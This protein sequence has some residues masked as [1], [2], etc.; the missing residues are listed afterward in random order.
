MLCSQ[1]TGE[2]GTFARCWALARRLAQRGHAVAIVSASRQRQLGI[3]AS[4]ASGLIVYEVGG[5]GPRKLR[6]TGL[7]PSD[8]VT[9][10]LGLARAFDIVHAFS[11]RP[12]VAVHA[13]MLKRSGLPLVFDW[14]D[15]N[16]F[17]GYADHRPGAHGRLVGAIDSWLERAMVRAAD[18]VTP[19]SSFLAERAV[20]FGVAEQ[21]VWLLPPGADVENVF[22]LDRDG[23]RRALG[24]PNDIEV[25]GFA[26]FHHWDAD[27]VAATVTR[28]FRRVPTLR[29]ATAGPAGSFIDR[30]L[31]AIWRGRLL[32]FPTLRGA[33]YRQF[34]A[35]CDVLVLPYPRRR[36]NLARYPNKIG[37]YLASGRAIVTNR[38]G[39]M[40]ELLARSQSALLVGE[41]PEELSEGVAA[42]LRNDRLRAT[43]GSRARTLAETECSW[44]RVTAR[45]ERAYEATLRRPTGPRRSAIRELEV[46]VG[47]GFEPV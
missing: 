30:Q 24:I 44:G 16:G 11:H 2:M 5:I 20:E 40:G 8:L 26:G 18:A 17:G 28:L 41:T 9:R 19:I 33:R 43:L 35:S 14:A 46:V 31:D 29:L 38:T 3:R 37:D 6:Q 34:L 42:C 13:T 21:A 45:L 32:R 23:A 12:V 36:Y 39:D 22:P 25:V 47:T 15:L 10:L 7:D 1:V 4:V 27:L